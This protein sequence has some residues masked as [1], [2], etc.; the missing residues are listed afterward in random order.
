MTNLYGEKI[1]YNKKDVYNKDG[2]IIASNV[3]LLNKFKYKR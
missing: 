1:D 3:E 2:F